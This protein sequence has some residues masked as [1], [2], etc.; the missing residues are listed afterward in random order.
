ML[1]R[2]AVVIVL[3]ACGGSTLTSPGD[4][5]P[6]GAL[7]LPSA[8]A[9]SAD[10]STDGGSAPD[11]ASLFDASLSGDASVSLHDGGPSP[12]LCAG[13]PGSPT[14][15]GC[16]DSDGN[17]ITAETNAACGTGGEACLACGAS[18]SCTGGTCIHPQPGCDPSNCAGCCQGDSSCAV[19][20][21]NAACGVAG[22]ACAPCL[23]CNPSAGGGGSCGLVICNGCSTGPSSCASGLSQASAAS[24][25]SLVT[26]AP[27]ASSVLLRVRRGASAR[28]RA[29][30]ARRTAPDA[31]TAPPAST[32]INIWS[33]ARGDPYAP[34]APDTVW[35]VRPGFA[36][37]TDPGV[38]AVPP[39]G[40]CLRRPKRPS[41]PRDWRRGRRRRRRRVARC[42]ERVRHGS[43]LDFPG[44]RARCA[45]RGPTGRRAR[46]ARRGPAGR[47]TATNRRERPPVVVQR[48][49]LPRGLLLGRRDV[50]H[51]ERVERVRL[52][53][54]ALRVLSPGRL[55]QGRLRALAGRL[56][57]VE[58][59][60]VLRQPEPLF[61]RSQRLQLRSGRRRMPALRSRRGFRPLRP[62][63]GRRWAV[64][65]RR[66]LH[67]SE[68][69]GMLRGRSLHGGR[70]ER[71]M[72]Q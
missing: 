35:R 33:A 18:A 68:L 27:V 32:E 12:G 44:R 13:G 19:G 38:A 42:M 55:L 37:E 1:R 24:T 48:D 28:T 10:T 30:A 20:S 62:A 26:R 21:Q 39:D 25:G 41:A 22:Q 66:L 3:A 31:A 60:R 65:R 40:L 58:L 36:V 7:T 70:H 15:T 51:V 46:R 49:D 50:R 8:D 43:R 69:S 61:D 63:G 54:R 57:S 71:C 67:R 56:Q 6:E 34:A 16:C 14:C 45:R 5:G 64:Q 47:R 52:R 53:R 29:H 4:G 9:T 23:D 2:G 17:C 11:A 72:R 59:Q